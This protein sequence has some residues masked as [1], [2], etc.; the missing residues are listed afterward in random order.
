PRK[1]Q[2]EYVQAGKVAD[3]LY[4][5]ERL[6]TFDQYAV[7]LD[8]DHPQVIIRTEGVPE[9][10]LL[11]V[12]DS[13]ANALLPFWALHFAE[14]HVLDLRYYHRPVSAYL[15]ENNIAEVLFLY[16]SLAVSSERVLQKLQ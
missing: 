15:K 5:P 13:Y 1:L 2:V 4:A 7:F 12:K 6:A 3:S 16:N 11:V 9:R 14:I 8:G 10:R